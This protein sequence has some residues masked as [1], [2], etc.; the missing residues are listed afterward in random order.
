[1]KTNFFN[2]NK[3]PSFGGLM[4]FALLRFPF[5]VFLCAAIAFAGCSGDDDP[6]P[7][8]VIIPSLSVAPAS[9]PAATDAGTYSIAVTS[10]TAW[11]AAVDAAA[12][13][14]TVS[15][16][17]G[18]GNGT[19]TVNVVFYAEIGNRAATVTFTAGALASTVTVTQQR[20]TPPYAA[21][22]QTRVFGDQTWSDA[23]QIPDCNKTDF[24]NDD[25]NPQCRSHTESGKTWYYY[26]WAHVNQNAAT[27]CPS[28]WRVPS[29]SDFSTLVSNLG[30]NNQTARD[31]IIAA[32]GYGGYA[33]G[34]SMGTVDSG[35]YYWSSTE[36]STTN[37]YN[38]YYG[39]S[40][41]NMLFN[42]KYN[43]FQVRCVK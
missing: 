8:P 34:S 4:G 40:N 18:N 36:N 19:V 37:A 7:E 9:I 24:T 17:S 3:L 21:S 2:N 39:S 11:T 22:T 42:T 33:Q 35:A 27:L 29:Q 41:L 43:G 12:T 10:N 30:G 5:A 25:N 6:E 32:W 16:T 23:I 1:M 31:A 14:C 28:P 20:D 13:W 15:P 26:N 38:L